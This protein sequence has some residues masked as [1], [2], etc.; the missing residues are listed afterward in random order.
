MEKRTGERWIETPG[1]MDSVAVGGIGN[2]STIN[3]KL[4]DP[5]C[6]KGNKKKVNRLIHFAREG[7][8]RLQLCPL[9]L[10]EL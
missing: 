2:P 6:R 5:I 9:L 4:N 1:A 7:M 3:N 10:W 8:L